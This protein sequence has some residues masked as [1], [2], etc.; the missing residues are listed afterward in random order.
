VLVAAVPLM[1]CVVTAGSLA[2]LLDKCASP[3]GN[4][5]DDDVDTLPCV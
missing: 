5:N 2:H 4:V 3:T 1:S